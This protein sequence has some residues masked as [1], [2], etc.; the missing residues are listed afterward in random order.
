MEVKFRSTC[1]ASNAIDLIGDKWS[2]LIVR[3]IFLDTITYSEFLKSAEKISTNILVDRLKKL[4]EAGFISFV[5]NPDDKKIKYYYLEN[6]GIDLFPI[7]C[8]MA[9]WTRSYLPL[10]PIHLKAIT[11]LNEIDEKGIDQFV[12]DYISTYKLKRKKLTEDLVIPA[13]PLS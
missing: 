2:L 4:I 1:P 3:D 6:K 12:H 8:Q 9:L 5:K 10:N 13:R 11:L 7:I